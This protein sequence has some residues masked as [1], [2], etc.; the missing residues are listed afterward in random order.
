MTFSDIKQRVEDLKKE[1][2]LTDKEVEYLT[3]PN[4]V[5]DFEFEIDKDDGSKKKLHGYRIQ[6]NRDLGPTKGGIRFHPHVDT[7]EVK[8]LAF[9]MALKCSLSGLPYGGAK[10]GVEINPKEYSS[11]ELEKV[12][13]AFVREIVDHVGPWKDVPAPDVYTTPQIMAWMLDEF[14]KIKGEHQPGFI[15]GKP[16]VLG[17]SKGRGYSTAQGGVYVLLEALQKFDIDPLTAKVAIQGFG[18]AGMNAALILSKE[19]LKVV[20]VSDSRGAIFNDDGL[21]VE[22]VIKHKQ[23]TKSVKDFEGAT[24]ISTEELLGLDV[25]VLVPAALENSITKDNANL[26]KAPIILELANGPVTKEAD[27]ILEEKG[28]KIIP[29]ILANAGGVIVSYYEWVQNNTGDYWEEDF[30]LEKLKKQIVNAFM[31]IY[32][33]MC[34][35]DISL[36]EAA[37]IVAI[38]RIIEAA[39]LRGNV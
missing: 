29:D 22:A 2:V 18:N 39:R 30:V 11:K 27:V 26:I 37:Y 35:E 36:R 17:G 16:L 7:D 14:E 19:G 31:N 32:K 33:P 15:T 21:D 3:T 8:S 4:K 25:E 13:R 1:I 12:S 28:I 38:K 20:A 6:F 10:G 24:N 5:L 9:W 34:D 23:S